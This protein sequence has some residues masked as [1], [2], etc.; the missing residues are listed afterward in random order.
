MNIIADATEVHCPMAV[1]YE[2][3]EEARLLLEGCGALTD[4]T[5]AAGEAAYYL[6][7]TMEPGE[8]E[9]L[10]AVAG[11][12]PRAAPDPAET[13]DRASAALTL[14]ADAAG[15]VEDLLR[16]PNASSELRIALRALRRGIGLL[17]ARLGLETNH[18]YAH[19]LEAERLGAFQRRRRRT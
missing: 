18:L 19:H 2:T 3:A 13:D 9:G 6:S 10:L 7:D 15:E 4:A 8:R 5:H 17:A 16:G 11:S 14:F 12:R 1:V